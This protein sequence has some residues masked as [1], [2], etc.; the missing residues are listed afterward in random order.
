M[1]PARF[2]ATRRG[3]LRGSERVTHAAALRLRYGAPVVSG[4][5]FPEFLRLRLFEPLGMPDT[6]FWVP[7]DKMDRLAMLYA[8]D[9]KTGA[10]T[11]TDAPPKSRLAS[12]PAFASGGG[13]LVSTADDYLRS[14]GTHGW[15]VRTAP[16]ISSIPKKSSSAS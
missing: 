12:P 7:A 10:S 5:P 15:G 2:C 1:K 11:A 6:A 14:K 3:A 9:P 4:M 8:L 16:G 13:G